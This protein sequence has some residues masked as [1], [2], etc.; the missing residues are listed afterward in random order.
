MEKPQQLPQSLSEASV[1]GYQQL[2]RFDDE[3]HIANGYLLERAALKHAGVAEHTINELYPFSLRDYSLRLSQLLAEPSAV[4]RV[5]AA[6]SGIY[7]FNQFVGAAPTS[8]QNRSYDLYEFLWPTVE[9]MTPA[10]K[11][12]LYMIPALLHL[13]TKIDSKPTEDWDAHARGEFLNRL[14]TLHE[15]TAALL[16]STVQPN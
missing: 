3:F 1:W 7:L 10:V 16:D 13:C 11:E 5:N 12:Q 8:V 14:P 6:L 2:L 9:G 15:A 4:Q